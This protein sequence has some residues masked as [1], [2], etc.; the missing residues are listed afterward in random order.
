ML[1]E[2]E[3]AVAG[4]LRHFGRR[5]TFELAP[6]AVCANCDAPLKG[7]F[8]YVC[9]Q[10]ADAHHRSILH[11]AWEAVEGLLHLDGRLLRTVPDLFLRP[12]R[13]ARDY[14]ENRIARHVPPFR[15]FLVALLLFVF[16]AEHATHQLQR[17][18]AHSRGHQADLSTP[19]GRAAEAAD[20]RR[21]ADKD[22]A[23]DLADAARDRTNDLKDGDSASSV[24]AAYTREAKRVQAR[25]DG[26]IAKA[27][28]VV[29]GLAADETPWTARAS[30]KGSW[31]RA[32]LHKATANPNYYLTV[33]FTW[34]HRAA[35]LLLPIVGCAPGSGLSQS[36]RDLPL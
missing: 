24:E 14:M 11:L 28:R 25:Y 7:Q 4:S 27:D 22:R 3:A 8:C 10:D 33:L 15:T 1:A 31:W 32:G 21:E 34:A 12:G 30:D 17:A 36:A 5:H 19:A 26:E 6:N 2:L 16:A 29:A 23:G 35:I 18:G 9:G 13:L 20:I